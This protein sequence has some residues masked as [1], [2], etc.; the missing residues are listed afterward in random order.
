VSGDARTQTAGSDP[1]RTAPALLV[2]RSFTNPVTN[3]TLL[4]SVDLRAHLGRILKRD[5]PVSVLPALLHEATHHDGFFSPVGTALVFLYLRARLRAFLV[6]FHGRPDED[7]QWGVLDDFLRYDATM[8][9]QTPLAE[10]LA[11]FAECDVVPGASPS[12]SWV[13][14]LAA[15]CVDQGKSQQDP[16][17]APLEHLAEKLLLMRLSPAFVERKANLLL[18]PMT[19]ETG[20]YLPGYLL[21]RNLWATAASQHRR[22]ND[23]DLFL[24]YMTAYFFG[25]FGMVAHLLDKETRDIDAVFQIVNHFAH[26]INAFRYTDHDSNLDKLEAASLSHPGD[27]SDWPDERQLNQFPHLDPDPDLWRLGKERWLAFVQELHAAAVGKGTSPTVA[28][29]HPS[30]RVRRRKRSADQSASPSAALAAR[31]AKSDLWTVAQR[32]LVCLGRL[33]VGVELTATGRVLARAEGMSLPI[34]AGTGLGT[35]MVGREAE[36][37]LEI[38]MNPRPWGQYMAVAVS[39]GDEIVMAM[40]DRHLD[41][42]VRQQ[43]LRYAT[44]L[45]R[46]QQKGEQAQEILQGV[47]DLHPDHRIMV[48]VARDVVRKWANETYGTAALGFVESEERR[49]DALEIMKDDGF[50]PIL[51]KVSLVRAL[52]WTSLF[53]GI[54]FPT[55]ELPGRFR[56]YRGVHGV[57]AGFQET[58]AEIRRRALAT[59]GDPLVVDGPVGLFSGV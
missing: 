21:V 53:T 40:F 31:L 30:S 14:S 17:H 7:E 5:L 13:S 32:E 48:E 44:N 10:G 24:Q 37:S 6:A 59:L 8:R 2:E 49:K 36:G 45:A 20:G 42:P 55:D 33:D 4:A 41:D 58:L 3:A 50:Y 46:S 51:G 35:G 15:M 16:S 11:I 38:F 18:Q 47:L 12:V 39:V 29:R 28:G 25:D 52:A 23:T 43:F 56:A 57:E 26:R 1:G 54:N 22:L 19:C 34:V 9:M 27:W